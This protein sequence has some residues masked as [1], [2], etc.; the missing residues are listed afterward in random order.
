MAQQPPVDLG[1]LVGRVVVEDEVHVEV[2]GDFAVEV[3][4]ELLEFGGAVAGVQLG[5]DPAGGDV[6]GGEQVG[7]A[8]AHVVVA[9][10]GGAGR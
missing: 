3:V 10:A 6:E 4:E 7:G 9:G 8:V 5:V 2:V 1:G